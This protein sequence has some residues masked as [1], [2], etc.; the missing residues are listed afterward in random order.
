MKYSRFLT[1][2]AVLLVVLCVTQMLSAAPR[3]S[4]REAKWESGDG[5][6][7][8]KGKGVSGAVVTLYDSEEWHPD[9]NQ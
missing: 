4:I 5:L 3:F 2:L 7:A 8:V 1:L 9:R 6:L